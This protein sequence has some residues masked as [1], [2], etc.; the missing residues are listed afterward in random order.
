[1]NF[2]GSCTRKNAGAR[3][4]LHNTVSDY[5]EI[6]AFNLNFKCTNNKSEYEAL[7][8]GLNL[9]KKIGAW[10][11]V[12]H[13]DSEL[14]IKQV[15]GEYTAK[16]PR[17]RAYKNDAMDLLKTFVEYELVFVPKSQNVISNGLAYIASSY[18]KTPSDKQIIIQTKFRP[19]VSDNEKY[20]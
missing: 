13:E 8:L 7:I 11:I 12:V 10:K 9:L 18:H 14:I 3:V 15:N 2:N 19:A 5:A 1:M 16:H 4:W 17:L 20:W 6:H